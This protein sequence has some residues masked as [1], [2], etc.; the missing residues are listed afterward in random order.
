MVPWLMPLKTSHPGIDFA[1][2]GAIGVIEASF[3]RVGFIPAQ[4][5]TRG[6]S[7]FE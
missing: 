7:D 4:E 2:K 1:K 6:G 5:V 3:L